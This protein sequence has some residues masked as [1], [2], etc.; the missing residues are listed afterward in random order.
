MFLQIAL[1]LHPLFDSQTM[2]LIIILAYDLMVEIQ[3]LFW[4]QQLIS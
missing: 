4:W 3:S 1:H 2:F